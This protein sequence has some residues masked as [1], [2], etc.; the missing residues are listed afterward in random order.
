MLLLLLCLCHAE[1]RQASIQGMPHKA[2]Y[3]DIAGPSG[4]A[5]AA[6]AAPAAAPA[7]AAAGE[8]APMDEDDLLQQAL[9]MSM[10]V[11]THGRPVACMACPA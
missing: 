8:A 3:D 7:A 5:E 9:A 11:C 4:S 1:G 2:Q 10:Q 6:E